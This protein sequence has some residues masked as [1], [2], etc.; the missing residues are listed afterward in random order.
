MF[1]Q[2][3][4]VGGEGGGGAGR[5]QARVHID[6]QGRSMLEFLK[7]LG[8]ATG[9]GRCSEG[10]GGL[11]PGVPVDD[12]QNLR[13]GI[14]FEK[15]SAVL[16]GPLHHLSR[17]LRSSLVM[18]IPGVPRVHPSY[19]LPLAPCSQCLTHGMPISQG[20]STKTKNGSK[21]QQEIRVRAPTRH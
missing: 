10:A 16:D 14:Q 1:G 12:A 11:E 3:A 17:D 19:P 18:V 7:S 6:N 21:P 2:G 9:G 13:L 20:T 5:S 15:S 4:E 8:K